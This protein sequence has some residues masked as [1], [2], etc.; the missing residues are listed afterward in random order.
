VSFPVHPD[1][2]SHT[3]EPCHSEKCPYT[4]CPENN[5][6]ILRA[7]LKWNWF[8]WMIE[9]QPLVIWTHNFFWK[10]RESRYVTS[11]IVFQDNQSAILLA[12]NGKA[13]S[14]RRTQHIDIRY[15]FIAFGLD[16]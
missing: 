9:C 16:Y 12:K 15:F 4:Q 3:G 11:N 14:G 5:A 6:S 7:L 1:M 10:C 13:S 8:V 2:R